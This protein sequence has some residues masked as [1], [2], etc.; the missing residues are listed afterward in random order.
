MTTTKEKIILLSIL[1]LALFFRLYGINWDQNHHLHPDERFLTMVTQELEFPENVSQ[2]FNPNESPL[3]PHNHGYTFFVY[4]VFPLKIVKIASEIITLDSFSYNNVTLVG[5]LLSAIFDVGTVALVFLIARNIF[6]KR[7]G[8]LA[9][10]LYSGMVL[11]IQLSHF[12]TVDP[13]L[14]FFI[15]AAFYFLILL[16]KSKNGF[17]YT[18]L[19]GVSFGLAL[20]S[21]VSAILFLPVIFAGIG[22]SAVFQKRYVKAVL[23]TIVFLAA[24]YFTF[25]LAD[26]RAFE[27]PNL[28]DPTINQNYIQSLTQLNQF[29]NPDTFFPPGIQWIGTTPLLYPLTNMV[30]WGLGLPLG[31]LIVSSVFYTAFSLTK[32]WLKALKRRNFK[33]AN[34]KKLLTS[35]AIVFILGVFFYQGSQFVK[36][37]RYFYPTYPFFA[38]IGADFFYKFIHSRLKSNLLL[39]TCY[40]LLLIWPL[41]FLQIYSRPHSRVAASNWIYQNIPPGSTITCEHWDDCLPLAL[42]NKNHTLYNIETLELFN[43]DSPQKWQVINGQIATADYIIMSSNRLWSSIPKV[44]EKYPIA[45]EFYNKLLSGEKLSFGEQF[46]KIAEFT[47]YPTIPF[48]NFKIPDDSAEEAFS[49]YDHPKVLIFKNEAIE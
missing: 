25:R 4:G 31:V 30:L 34:D 43:P 32:Y 18:T 41:S 47:S 35:L 20:A 12:Y 13:Y 5:R 16:L 9:A 14:T 37:L 36:T 3:N 6:G 29:N 46:E 42:G 44:P 48:L 49:V 33:G 2:Y 38:I 24:S 11:P 21:K 23:I 7:E 28:L 15:T 19:L 45:S 22:Y 8:L 40:L 10:F 39:V 1:F 27:S 26:P 17:V